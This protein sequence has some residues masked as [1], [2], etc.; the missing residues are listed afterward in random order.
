MTKPIVHVE[1]F[2]LT[3]GE[4]K[5]VKNLNFDVLPGEVFAFLG[6]NGSGKTST[7]RSLLGIYQQTTGEL[8]VNGT[9]LTPE[10]AAVV[11][12][13]P[14]ERGLYTRSKVLDTMIYFGELKGMTRDDARDFSV[15]FL[16]RVE[17]ADKANI[18]I[19]KLSG[20]QQQKIQLGV[21]IMGDPQLLILDEPTKGLDPV[22]RKL[23][24]DIVDELQ[25]KG[26]A[27][28]YITHLMEEVERLA[29]RLLILKDGVARAYGTVAEVKEEFTST[30]IEDIFVQIYKEKSNV[31]GAEAAPSKKKTT[32]KEG[33]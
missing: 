27:V 26:T 5:I 18:K 17:L 19:K 10:S 7:I 28:I 9:P 15:A 25:E 20:G 23:L 16:E 13:L 21:A 30:S 1:D 3:I 14:E 22:N 24:L 12:Y 8:L 11:G 33:K 32:K 31:V 2:S 4:K 6:A 29:D